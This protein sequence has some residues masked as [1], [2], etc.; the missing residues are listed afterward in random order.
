MD[1][2]SKVGTH[3]ALT[4]TPVSKSWIHS[5]LWLTRGSHHKVAYAP[6]VTAIKALDRLIRPV[7]LALLLGLAFLAS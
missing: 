4:E 6:I 2:V 5:C 1:V 7:K 3:F